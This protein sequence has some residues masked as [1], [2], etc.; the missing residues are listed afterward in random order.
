MLIEFSVQNYCSFKEQQRLSLVANSGKELK[1]E[2][3]ITLPNE[4]N[5]SLVKSSVIYG[6]NAAGKSNLIKAL[7]FMQQ[8]ILKSARE[9]EDQ[10]PIDCIPFL[11]NSQSKGMPSEFE[12]IFISE[13]VRYQYG[14]AVTPNRVV[15][16]W[17]IAYPEKRPQQWFVR[18]Y[19]AE[20]NEEEWKFGSKMLG[21]SKI[22]LWKKMT[23]ADALFLSIAHQF[24]SEQL[25]PVYDWFKE[26]L[27]I[28]TNINPIPN[29]PPFF[30]PFHN[31]FE[32]EPRKAVEFLKP[33][34]LGFSDIQV[35]NGEAKIVN[36]DKTMPF[37]ALFFIHLNE[38]N[39]QIEF[40]SQME[41]EGTRRLVA[42]TP[43]LL[44][45]LQQ[46]RVLVVDEIDNSLHPLLVRGILKRFQNLEGQQSNAQMIC[47]THDVS[48]LDPEL[49]RRDQIWF[50]EK[51]QDQ[52][53]DLYSL[54]DFSPRKHEAFGKG[55][56]EGRYGALPFI[57]EWKFNE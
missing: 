46:Q 44:K 4:Q 52:S 36:S 32:T 30:I 20:T 27:I 45:I 54:A 7:F 2:N 57:G 8:F 9:K 48:L 39:E 23:R 29:L 35:K 14:F 41:S 10:R 37:K 26:N 25:K 33:F 17:L 13:G 31:V 19:N 21:G 43:H 5:F 47:S 51:K 11:L 12:I 24:N 34:D 50:V 49:L 28:I 55:Y 38:K 15:K 1:A 42:L 53:T 6:A 22:A 3:T 40:H 18:A 56:L 16:E